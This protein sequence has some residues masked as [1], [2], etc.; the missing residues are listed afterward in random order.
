MPGHS[1]AVR[2]FA[3]ARIDDDERGHAASR[4]VKF[5]FDRIDLACPALFAPAELGR[6]DAARVVKRRR[7]GLAEL[8]DARAPH[9]DI[10]QRQ[11]HFLAYGEQHL[12]ADIAGGAIAACAARAGCRRRRASR[13]ARVP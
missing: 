11:R 10:L 1:R 12:R 8:A 5:V 7:A 2:P 6:H 13:A 9:H 4:K 3:G